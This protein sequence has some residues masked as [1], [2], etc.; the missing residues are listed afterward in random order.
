[1]ET[2]YLLDFFGHSIYH[3]DLVNALSQFGIKCKDKSKLGRYDSLKNDLNT[4]TFSFWYK[5]FYDYQI[6]TPKST[7]KSENEEEVI[8]FEMTFSDKK[9][10]FPFGIKVGDS[11][12]TVSTKIGQKP[13]SKSKNIDNQ[14]TWTYFTEYFEVMPVFNNN[15]EL[16]WLRI[17]SIKKA[18]KKKIELKKEL[19]KQN[20]NIT[21]E[22]IEK[23]DLLI[24]SLPSAHWSNRKTSNEIDYSQGF[25]EESEIVLKSFIENILLATSKKNASSVYSAMKKCVKSFNKINTKFENE[26]CSLERE[27]I[28]E[29]IELAIRNTG[30]IIEQNIDLTEEYR[31]W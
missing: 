15:L 5:E 7:Y 11:S 23:L 19:R 20:K 14:H 4:I 28:I 18:D 30:F 10:I 9:V 27:E 22:N 21:I 26:L 8:L 6:G 29:F 3:P 12:A 16:K 25:L 24:K 31:N 13:N 17:W 2:N 1:M